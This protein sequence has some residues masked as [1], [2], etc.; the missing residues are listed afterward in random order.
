[1]VQIQQ[2]SNWWSTFGSEMGDPTLPQQPGG[3]DE[4][5]PTTMI[6]QYQQPVFKKPF[7]LVKQ[8]QVIPPI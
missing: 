3:M 6:T 1:M 5:I 2:I 4:T 8:F 7:V